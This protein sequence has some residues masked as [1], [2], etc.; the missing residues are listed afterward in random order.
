MRYKNNDV[1]EGNWAYNEFSGSGEY[2]EFENS[3]YVGDYKNGKYHGNGT[4]TYQNG[5]VYVGEF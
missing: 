2:V 3:K 5:D 4:M 1:Y